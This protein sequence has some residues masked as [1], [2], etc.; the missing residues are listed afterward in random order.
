MLG[1]LISAGS[2]LLGSAVGGLFGNYQQ[3]KALDADRQRIRTLVNDAKQAGIHPLY[4]LGSGTS[5]G[6]AYI[7]GQ[8]PLGDHLAQGIQQAGQHLGDYFD[9][10]QA[11]NAPRPGIDP[12]SQAQVDELRSRTRRNDLE[13]DILRDQEIFRRR[14]RLLGNADG[15]GGMQAA[16]E[17]N[18]GKEPGTVPQAPTFVG[19]FGFTWQ[20]QNRSPSQAVE[21]YYGDAAS[22]VYGLGGL[23]EDMVYDQ[24]RRQA[25]NARWL[26]R[27]YPATRDK[28]LI[29][30]RDAYE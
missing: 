29:N 19:P 27:K 20:G 21:D 25:N 30:W 12:V 11:A 13:T 1:S 6:G 23:T 7:A 16:V 8:S 10:R 14:Q 22:W 24:A 15:F 17:G 9:K 4:A 2:S 26:S 5:G 18:I 28:R 3:N